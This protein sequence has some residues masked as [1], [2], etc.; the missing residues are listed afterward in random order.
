[1][2]VGCR[3]GA[4]ECDVIRKLS[5]V[6]VAREQ[7]SGLLTHLRHHETV[8]ARAWRTEAPIDISEYAEAARHIAGIRQGQQRNLDRIIRRDEHRQF[9]ADAGHGMLK[10][11]H[12]RGVSDD[13]ASTVGAPDQ[14]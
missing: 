5:V 10:T 4:P 11:R 8:L 13:P 2:R 14:W 6:L 12:A 3:R 7:A 9:V 1:M